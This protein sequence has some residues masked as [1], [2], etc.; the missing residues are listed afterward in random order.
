MT[1]D[2][3]SPALSLYRFR[4]YVMGQ[5][6]RSQAAEEQL[7]ALCRERL[8]D[9]WRVDVVDVRGRPDVADAARIVA[10]PTLDRLEP[11]PFTRVIGDLS[12][13]E[14]LAAA[15]DLPARPVTTGSSHGLEVE[16]EEGAADG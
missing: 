8:G 3:E 13:T 9:R 2:G 15:L 16:L 6:A 1:R 12:S 11:E 14:R 7:R 10:T 4:L 5:T